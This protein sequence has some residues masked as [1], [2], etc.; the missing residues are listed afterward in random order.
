MWKGIIYFRLS[1]EACHTKNVRIKEQVDDK[2]GTVCTH[3]FTNCLLKNISTKHN[4]YVINQNLEHVD[5]I[6]FRKLNYLAFQSFNFDRTWRRLFQKRVVRTKFDIHVLIINEKFKTE[7]CNHLFGLLVSLSTNP[8]RQSRCEDQYMVQ[9]LS[10]LWYLLFQVQCVRSSVHSH[11]TYI[12]SEKKTYILWIRKLKDRDFLS[13]S[14][15]PNSYEYRNRSAEKG[16]R[17]YI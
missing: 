10:Y 15:M 1:W 2:R 12:Y 13:P 14:M 17:C 11:Q 6:S 7:I 8:H 3:R 9:F 4:K 16:H 5:D